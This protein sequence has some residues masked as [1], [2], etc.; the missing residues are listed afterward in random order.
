MAQ[1]SA[2]AWAAIRGYPRTGGNLLAIG[3]RPLFVQSTGDGVFRAAARRTT[4]GACLPRS[5]RFRAA[6]P[7]DARFAVWDD[8]F[9]LPAAGPGAARLRAQH[10]VS[11]AT[12]GPRTWAGEAG[13]LR[14]ARAAARRGTVTRLDSRC[15]EAG[16]GCPARADRDAE[17]RARPAA[18][19]PP[20]G[21]AP[22]RDGALHAARRRPS[23]GG[24]ASFLLARGE[25]A[26]IVLH[27][28]DH[29]SIAGSPAADGS[30]RAAA[31]RAVLETRT[32]ACPRD[33]LDS[34]VTWSAAEQPGLLR[35]ACRLRERDGGIVDVHETGFW[36]LD[37]RCSRGQAER[38]PHLPAPGRPT[39]LPVGV[40]HWVNDSVWSSF[41]ERERPGMGSRLRRAGEPRAELR[42]RASGQAACC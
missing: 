34:E 41:P 12:T 11:S 33:R 5:M 23:C 35:R 10:R 26:K 40:N 6:R 13:L 38:G 22:A 36:R 15:R 3:G 8:G 30:R 39:C 7:G 25:P 27:V 14:R 20:D 32:I 9:G 42:A 21:D 37:P 19:T 31:R 16:R 24:A 18:G 17:L 29:R 2:D 1:P 4:T 28:L